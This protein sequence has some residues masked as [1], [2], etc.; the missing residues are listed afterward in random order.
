MIFVYGSTQTKVVLFLSIPPDLVQVQPDENQIQ[1]SMKDTTV[2]RGSSSFHREISSLLKGR[3]G[4]WIE[5][6]ASSHPQKFHLAPGDVI[7]SLL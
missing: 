1:G 4:F 5:R 6:V 7:W 2:S 3:V